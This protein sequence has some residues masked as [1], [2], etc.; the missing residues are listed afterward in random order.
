LSAAWGQRTGQQ[1]SPRYIYIVAH[2][3]HTISN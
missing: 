2:C 3:I 1:C